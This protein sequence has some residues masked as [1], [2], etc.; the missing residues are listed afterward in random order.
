MKKGKPTPSFFFSPRTVVGVWEGLQWMI[1][2]LSRQFPGASNSV[3]WCALQQPLTIAVT[4][5]SS[6]PSSTRKH[7]IKQAKDNALYLIYQQTV[8]VKITASGAIVTL[9]V[10]H[11][12]RLCEWKSTWHQQNVFPAVSIQRKQV[13]HVSG[14]QAKRLVQRSCTFKSAW[15]TPWRYVCSL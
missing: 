6:K 1:A 11:M 10:K 14:A 12:T 13:P 5:S 4:V 9:A 7:R 15:L 8:F 2:F 3:L